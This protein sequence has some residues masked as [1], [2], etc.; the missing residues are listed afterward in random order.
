MGSLH[1]TLQKIRSSWVGLGVG[2][3]FSLEYSFHPSFQRFSIFFS[4][5][6][7]AF[8]ASSCCCHFHT[9]QRTDSQRAF[10]VEIKCDYP[11]HQNLRKILLMSKTTGKFIF[12]FK[13]LMMSQKHVMSYLPRKMNS[14]FKLNRFVKHIFFYL[15]QNKK[16]ILITRLTG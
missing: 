9:H 14:S 10:N 5:A 11:Q 1:L 7:S 13:W 8:Q 16:G 4:H 6:L 3:S 2:C 12:V 15:C